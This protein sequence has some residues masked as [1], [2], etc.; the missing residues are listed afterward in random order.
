MLAR[1]YFGLILF[2]SII[3]WIIVVAIILKTDP[4]NLDIKYF[5]LFFSSLLIGF[6]G[7]FTFLGYFVR[8][9]VLKNISQTHL[10]ESIRQGILLSLA[11]VGLLLLQTAKVLNWWDGILLVC[12]I[13]L[14]EFYF[15]TK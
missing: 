1:V 4:N 12:A 8:R 15:R 7:F 6:V 14:L 10:V 2:L 5:V 13:L 11:G 9:K 3:A